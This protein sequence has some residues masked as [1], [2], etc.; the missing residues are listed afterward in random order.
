MTFDTICSLFGER[1]ITDLT[2]RKRF[3]KFHSGNMKLQGELGVG[4]PAE[5]DDNFLKAI[6]DQ[7]LHQATNI[8][9]MMYTSQH[10]LPSSLEIRKSLQMGFSQSQ[11]KK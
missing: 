4:C 10:C 7:N 1:Q 11:R 3:A 5:F 6:L 2:V 8:V 9:K